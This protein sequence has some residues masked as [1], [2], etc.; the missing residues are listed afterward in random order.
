VSKRRAD[1]HPKANSKTGSKTLAVAMVP[2]VTL[3]GS[4]VLLAGEDDATYH[5]LLIRVR[6]AIKPVDFIDE[7]FIADVVSLGW[8]ILRWRRLKSS[9][10]QT[11]GLE[12]LKQFLSKHLDD[13]DHYQTHFEQD[14]ATSFRTIALKVRLKM[15]HA[16]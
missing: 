15:M 13:Y 7:I 12:A 6:T 4:P 2:P 3:F 16:G 11:R 10:M 1:L 8:E 9:L 14:L 5:E